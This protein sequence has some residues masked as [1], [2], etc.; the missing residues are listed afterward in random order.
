MNDS[1]KSFI[2]LVSFL[3]LLAA[4][5]LIVFMNLNVPGMGGWVARFF[6]KTGYA[7]RGA[8]A[9]AVVVLSYSELFTTRRKK[10][11]ADKAADVM[12]LG[13]L[14]LLFGALYTLMHE[15]SLY[16]GYSAAQIIYPISLL[17]TLVFAVLFGREVGTVKAVTIEGTPLGSDPDI[18]D[19]P[20]GFWFKTEDGYL[21]VVNPFQGVFVNGGAGA[22]KTAS[23]AHPVIAQMVHN[24]WT[25]IVYDFKFFDLTNAVYT[26][27]MK[28]PESFENVPLYI[29][30]FSDM[31]RTHR[32]NPLHPRYLTDSIFIEE[33]GTTVL[34]N[35]N[36]E[37]IKKSDFFITSAV[38]T[39]KAIII[40]FKNQH[41]ELCDLAHI[42]CFCNNATVEQIVHLLKEDRQA[43]AVASS[44]KEAVEKEATEQ[45]A[46]VIATL[47]A[48][49]QKLENENFYW[50][51]SPEEDED[52]LLTLNDQKTPG[53]LCLVND[54]QK[55]D[56]ISPIISLIITVCRKMMNVKGKEKSIFLLDEAPT[57]YLP[58]F[59]ELPNTGRSNRICAFYMGQ[60]I[61]QMDTMYGK[62]IR[63]NI[64][65]SLGNTFFG[66]AT[67]GET[68]KYV[69][70]F[71][72]KEDK[73]V[74]N[75]SMGRNKST[76]S[77]GMS[78]N[79]SFNVQERM[80]IKPQEVAALK[81]GEFAGKIVG[82]ENPF[83]KVRFK[84]LCDYPEP[85]N[86]DPEE[87]KVPPFAKNVDVLKNYN[88]VYENIF[89][90]LNKEE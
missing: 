39:F 13:F 29:V 23:V 55:T 81:I 72:G 25:G 64:L 84:R 44:L 80:I 33:F 12:L 14:F 30:N 18:I 49:T 6:G 24:G 16:A 88:R 77:S 19:N 76:G 78:E 79:I 4:I 46:G 86:F 36:K 63:R 9:L 56:T 42:I 73:I 20:N 83:Y 34:K 10:S 17:G 90:I 89:N 66:N 21:N 52:I 45:I 5:D 75:T 7:F 54:Q 68:L 62:D 26:A 87:F 15:V 28:H 82:R 60:D 8:F 58:R 71:F 38:L 51:L 70:D 65:G 53:M 40:W 37:W 50:V 69:S 85:Y 31:E 74:E 61:S 3:G 48:E 2:V 27:Y 35:L 1:K 43:L 59:E 47:K 11:G 41:P 22:G 67:E 32:I 57:L